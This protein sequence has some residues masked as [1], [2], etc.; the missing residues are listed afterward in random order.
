MN[1][2]HGRPKMGSLPEAATRPLRCRWGK[3]HSA[4]EVS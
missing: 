4:Q 3:A 2:S 1:P